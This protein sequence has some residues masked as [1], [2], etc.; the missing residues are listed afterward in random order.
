[1]KNKVCVT[2]SVTSPSIFSLF[3]CQHGLKLHKH[4][5]RL[6]K[7]IFDVNCSNVKTWV[8][9]VLNDDK[10]LKIPPVYMKFQVIL[11]QNIFFVLTE[12]LQSS[13]EF[14]K[15]LHFN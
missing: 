12:H 2:A 10:C 7:N 14:F 6:L 5:A 11:L 3:K 9:S 13:S 4:K 1:M 15:I 8:V